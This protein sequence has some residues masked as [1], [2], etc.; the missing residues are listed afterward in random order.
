MNSSVLLVV[1]MLGGCAVV[2]PVT[3][4]TEVLVGDVRIAETNES[5]GPLQV[6]IAMSNATA[7]VTALWPRKCSRVHTRTARITES[8]HMKVE[9]S[10]W[11]FGPM[12]TAGLIVFAVSAVVTAAHVVLSPSTTTFEDRVVSGKS[13]SCW[14]GAHG[15][16][17]QLTLPSG[18][19]LD[20]VTNDRASIAFTIPD[21]EPSGALVARVG[22]AVSPSVLY[23]GADHVVDGAPQL[24]ADPHDSPLPTPPDAK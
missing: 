17:V 21:I 15:I 9:H 1:A 18:A 10:G 22:T 8:K 12:P 19:V 6:R 20:G 7:T 16:G 3:K 11:G 4:Q 13:Y 24:D 23:R 2:A 5:S 14:V